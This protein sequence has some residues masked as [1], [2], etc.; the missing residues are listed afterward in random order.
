MITN[1]SSLASICWSGYS[2]F[3]YYASKAALNQA[4]VATALEFAN[5]GIRANA[6]FAGG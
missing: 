6:I 3:A 5:K 1:I 2:Y 4:T